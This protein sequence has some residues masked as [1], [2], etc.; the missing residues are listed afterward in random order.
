[1]CLPNMVALFIHIVCPNNERKMSQYSLAF[2]NF[3]F[4]LILKEM[5]LFVL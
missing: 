2:Y 1:M 5:E 3:Y 4:D